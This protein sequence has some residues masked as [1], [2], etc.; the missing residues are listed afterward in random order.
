ML[1]DTID[2]MIGIDT[3]FGMAKKSIGIASIGR[4][5]NISSLIGFVSQ[6]CTTL[7]EAIK[8]C[9]LLLW[10]LPVILQGEL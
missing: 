4:I 9:K 3:K 6:K 5:F 1:C 2:T 10:C 8:V 7:R